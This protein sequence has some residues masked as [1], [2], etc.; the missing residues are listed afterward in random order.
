VRER[1]RQQRYAQEQH[2]RAFSVPTR[3]ITAVQRERERC[4]EKNKT[5]RAG[6]NIYIQGPGPGLGSFSSSTAKLPRSPSFVYFLL[7]KSSAE[8]RGGGHNRRRSP[9]RPAASSN[10]ARRRSSATEAIGKPAGGSES[11]RCDTRLQALDGPQSHATEPTRSLL[12]LST[13]ALCAP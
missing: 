6:E 3:E 1:R 9:S 10:R 12:P 4:K 5:S 2:R 11:A 8:L 7:L 13:H